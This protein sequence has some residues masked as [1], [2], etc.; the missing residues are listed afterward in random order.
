[1][2]KLNKVI[3]TL[4]KKFLLFLLIF[5][6]GYITCLQVIVFFGL[7]TRVPNILLAR[8]GIGY[9]FSKFKEA[10]T[11]DSVNLLFLGSSHAYRSFDT[12]FYK[13]K[14][15]KPL[16]LGTSSQDPMNTYFITQKY[17]NKFKPNTVVIETY[18]GMFESPKMEASLDLICNTPSSKEALDI[19]FNQNRIPIYNTFIVEYTQRL[20][21]DSWKEREP[22]V[23]TDTDVYEEGGF[24]RSNKKEFDTTDYKPELKKVVISE[25]QLN[26]LEQ[27]IKL[28]QSVGSKVILV[29]APVFKSYKESIQNYNDTIEGIQKL[30][31]EYECPFYDFNNSINN[32]DNSFFYDQGHMSQKGVDRFSDMFYNKLKRILPPS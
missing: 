19:V 4:C 13:E 21:G 1:M 14:K 22:E 8:G 18:W 11:K 17:I 27:I 23:N 32:W 12:K 30:S 6:V 31:E 9:T 25:S 10:E 5:F 15:F 16:N 20:F 3:L 2:F 26:Y 28:C 29:R 24:V 7:D